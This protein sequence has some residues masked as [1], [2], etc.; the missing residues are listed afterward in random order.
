MPSQPNNSSI[1]FQIRN[2]RDDIFELLAS[3]GH[4][5]AD[6]E[7]FKFDNYLMECVFWEKFHKRV[8]QWDKIMFCQVD[9]VHFVDMETHAG[10]LI[11]IWDD[12]MGDGIHGKGEYRY[13]ITVS[14]PRGWENGERVANCV[15][16]E[17][18]E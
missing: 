10:D 6:Y 7:E 3:E 8:C 16:K 14:A 18:D 9:G 17:R 5:V 11:A 13:S 1:K 12:L 2:Q 15:I 4:D